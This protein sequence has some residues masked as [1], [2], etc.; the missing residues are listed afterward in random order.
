[1]AISWPS[2][3]RGCSAWGTPSPSRNR[4]SSAAGSPRTVSGLKGSV[5]HGEQL[6]EQHAQGVDVGA[7]IDVLPA[8]LRLLGL[9]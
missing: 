5:P 3:R 7:G 1:M 8:A 4:E 2:S 9:M 6:V